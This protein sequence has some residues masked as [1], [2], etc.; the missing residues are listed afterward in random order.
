MSRL[1]SVKT[2][3]SSPIFT[4]VFQGG[5]VQTQGTPSPGSLSL[6]PS[7]T[8]NI[9]PS[10]TANPT[11][12]LTDPFDSVNSALAWVKSRLWQPGATVTLRLAAG[13]W[14]D[15][16]T[17][18]LTGLPPTIFEG[19]GSTQV[20]TVPAGT[21]TGIY[22]AACIG[23]IELVLPV[24]DTT[25]FSA[26]DII[27]VV[28]LINPHLL[29]FAEAFATGTHRV[30]SVGPGQITVSRSSQY[31]AVPAGAAGPIRINTLAVR[32]C[33]S[34]LR[35]GVDQQ[36][37][38]Q[39]A[40]LS[41]KGLIIDRQPATTDG[42]FPLIKIALGTLTLEDLW[43]R[44]GDSAP[45]DG[46][47]YEAILIEAPLSDVAIPDSTQWVTLSGVGNSYSMNQVTTANNVYRLLDNSWGGNSVT[48][49]A[50]RCIIP[51]VGRFTWRSF[52]HAG[53]LSPTDGDFLLQQCA[54]KTGEL[55]MGFGRLEI[56]GCTIDAPN[57]TANDFGLI[58]QRNDNTFLQTPTYS[59]ALNTQGNSMSLISTN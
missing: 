4:K 8:L 44:G 31:D 45:I 35:F 52:I 33:A 21:T 54:V 7:A 16:N 25:P 47:A 27:T 20:A 43:L 24:S 46:S 32:K 59:P 50:D 49:R 56:T 55:A 17:I 40:N 9:S 26:G 19:V 5:L 42:A 28:P 6:T 58:N 23:C 57:V 12:P 36:I 29:T 14:D 13:F 39:Q 51:T 41:L 15:Q 38:G 48:L 11:D 10:G 30:I 2:K 22:S 3:P 37:K 34:R 1:F 18:D 53:A